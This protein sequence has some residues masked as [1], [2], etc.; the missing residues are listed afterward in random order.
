MQ[1]LKRYNTETKETTTLEYIIRNGDTIAHGKLARYNKEGKKVK[2]ANFINGEISGEVINYFDTGVIK[3]MYY[4]KLDNNRIPDENIE[5]FPSGKIMS[6]TLYDDLGISAFTIYFDEKGSVKNYDG[7]PILEIHQYKIENKEKFKTK[8]NRHL[9]VGD[10]VKYQFLIASIPN[11]KR[12]ITIENLDV[13][14]LTA[15][16]TFKQMSR[17]SFDVEEILTEKGIN[18]I[19]AVVKYEF[20]NKEKKVI[21]A[22]IFFK[23]EVN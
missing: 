10:T 8:T 14:N 18:T 6:Y 5:N 17:V 21:N 12:D 19:R 13:D 9:K 22:M 7:Y 11:V 2:D 4:Y 23:V 1:V 16:R 3:S 15:K 20:N